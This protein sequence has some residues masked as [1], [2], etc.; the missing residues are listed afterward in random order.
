MTSLQNF[1]YISLDIFRQITHNKP[2]EPDVPMTELDAWM[3]FLSSDEPADI[4]RIIT[5][6]PFFQH[7]Y[8]DIVNFRFNPKELISMYSE[9]LRIM[10]ENTVKYMIDEL[11]EA[12]S[13]KDSEISKMGSEISKKD[14]EIEILRAQLAKYE[15]PVQTA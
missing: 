5:E 14:S 8:Q 2:I 9:A 15:Q 10:D 6:F 1:I 13:L 11:K 4:L 3:Y 12:L 7:L